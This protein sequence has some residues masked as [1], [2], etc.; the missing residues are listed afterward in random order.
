MRTCDICH[1]KIPLGSDV[2]PNCGYRMPKSHS[3]VRAEHPRPSSKLRGPTLQ[4]QF[5]QSLRYAR[6]KKPAM[7]RHFIRWVV[8]LCAVVFAVFGLAVPMAVGLLTDHQ[9]T[10]SET[11]TEEYES[12][13][14]LLDAYP[15]MTTQLN[16]IQTN[17]DSISN[18]LNLS[19]LDYEDYEVEDGELI[20]FNVGLSTSYYKQPTVYFSISQFE[21][22]QTMYS[23]MIMYEE[24]ITDFTKVDY[25]AFDYFLSPD[26]SY[27]E[28][29]ENLH[30]QAQANDDFY[31]GMDYGNTHF[32]LMCGADEPTHFYA[33]FSTKENYLK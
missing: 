16:T 1:T 19:E 9:P 6:Q 21:D 24:E 11:A 10:S 12:K 22:S 31:S 33:T 20:Y 18:G 5:E 13:E 27:A 3:Q 14:S 15:E 17:L 7:P 2:C 29:F 25:T 4:Q 23:I 32:S 28:L 30:A 26:M 8:G